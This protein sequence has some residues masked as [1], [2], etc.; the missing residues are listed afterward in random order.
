VSSYELMQWLALGAGGLVF[1]AVVYGLFRFFRA[2]GAIFPETAKHY[3]LAYSKEDSSGLT[4]NKNVEKLQGV[5]DGIPLQLASTY[6]TRGRTRMR[7]TWAATHA[8]AGWTPCTVNISRTPPAAKIHLAKTG[9]ANFDRQR[10]ATC[11]SPE[12]ATAMLGPDVR[13]ALLRCPQHE[14]RIVVD[15]GNL[16][17]S[18]PGTP[19]NQ[20]ELRGAIDVLLAL[21]RSAAP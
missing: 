16:V 6:E 2:M 7:G 5:V 1:L 21:A 20:A 9:D 15:G 17:L 3:G 18:F 11:D 4:G 8:P 19:N 14:F 10:F 13:A 12:R